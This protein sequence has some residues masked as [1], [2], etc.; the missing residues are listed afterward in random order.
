MDNYNFKEI[1]AKWQKKWDEMQLH[2]TLE[3]T[4]KPEFYMLEMFP[5][6]SGNLH[7][8]HVRNYSIG[9]VI[10]RFKR[11]NGYNVLHPMGWDSFGLPAE[12]AAIKHGIHPSKWTWDNIDN[13]RR[14]LK[15]LGISYDWDREVA[16][17]HP[18]Y[19]RWTQ[20]M[21]LQFYKNGLAYRKKSYAN[22]CPSCKTVLANEQVVDGRCERCGS[23]VS[24]KNLEQWFFKI[25]AYAERLLND[26]ERLEGWPDKVK[27]MQKNWI[28]K[29]QGAELLFKVDGTDQVI[30]IFTTRPD[31]VFGVTYIVLAPEHPLVEALTRGTSYEAKVN[32]FIEKVHR[33]SEI[34][35]TSTET[36]KEGIFIG[37]YAINPISGDRVPIWIANYVLLDYGT[38]AVMGV[39]A[40][41]QRDFQFA[42]KYNLPIKVV[43]TPKDSALNAEEM[44][45]AYEEPG[46]M[47][48]SGQFNGIS[49]QDMMD[50]IIE[51]A[52]KKGLGKRKVNYRLRDWLISRQRYW[53]APIPIVYCDRCGIV[54][55]PEHQ[56]PVMLPTDV[57]FTGQGESPLAECESFV[58]TT[59]P[60]CG[61]PARRE[62]DT[63]DTFICSSWYFMRYT[64]PHNA[65]MPFDKEK[66]ARWMPVD[67][68]VGGVEHAILHLLYSRFFTKVLYDLGYS[69][70]DEPFV[71]LLTQ[72]M[73]L[74]DGSKMSKSKGNVVSPEEIVDKYGADTARL[75]ILFAAPPEKD[76]EWSDQGVEGC[77]RFLNR[78]WRI[79]GESLPL[80]R[81]DGRNF[82]QLSH[83]DKELRYKTHYTIKK[84]TEDIS[85]RF[86]FNTA[87]SAIMEMV[88]ALYQYADLEEEQKNPDVISEALDNLVIL[89]SPFAPHITEE[90]WHRMGH[91][92]SIHMVPWPDYDSKALIKDEM[93]LVIQ[94]NGKVR[95][96][97]TV[98]RDENEDNIKQM[99]MGTE[100]I[101]TLVDGKDIVKVIYV[102]GK[103]VNIVVR[104]V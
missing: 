101:K 48:N 82:T 81:K 53:G 98:P 77:Y 63:M 95:D 32:K 69:P 42:K 84:V 71:N 11:M 76:L 104:E 4:S 93:Q 78:V 34:E 85:T 68:Y 1:E 2:K 52:E 54:P 47:V 75:F 14:Q 21:F 64:D 96:K 45:E 19:Y 97:I 79:V 58:H 6:P 55:V 60:V 80:Y 24:K 12:N 44:K 13:M 83:A 29:S 30:P 59:C 102:K 41:D 9:D 28:G 94:V 50:K 33:M 86:N 22:W 37:A 40:H 66:A 74:K 49:S 23:E 39:P 18:D 88:N 73:V 56:L 27:V 36:E 100:K 17:C 92:E 62:T 3:D 25:T 67:Q 5:Y 38:G 87:I 99:A 91:E 20:W 103:L 16:T 90:L 57:E 10:A 61:G 43:I 70:V 15:Q 89:L 8:G 65:E 51:Y 72:G 31:T 35:R 26:I 7:M 46:I